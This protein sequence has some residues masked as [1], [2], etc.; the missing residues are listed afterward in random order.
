MH[1]LWNPL[2]KLEL[3]YPQGTPLPLLGHLW[4]PLGPTWVPFGNM[5]YPTLIGPLVGPQLVPL[6]NGLVPWGHFSDSLLPFLLLESLSSNHPIG[7]LPYY[8]DPFFHCLPFLVAHGW[9]PDFG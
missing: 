9:A 5:V 1:P 4:V 8:G 7:P 6:G 2:E 3:S